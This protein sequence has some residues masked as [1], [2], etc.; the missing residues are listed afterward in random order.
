MASWTCWSRVFVELCKCEV[1][2][3][4]RRVKAVSLSE[5]SSCSRSFLRN[6]VHED[7]TAD[8]L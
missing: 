2:W 3:Q 8:I 6:A 5:N 7:A 1:G 4:G